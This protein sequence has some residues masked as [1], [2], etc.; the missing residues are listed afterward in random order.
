MLVYTIEGQQKQI[1][2]DKLIAAVSR[3]INPSGVAEVTVRRY[4]NEQ[5][6]VI[7]PEVEQRE[8]DQI[9]RII[10]TSGNLQF[11][12]LA[13]RHDHQRHHRAGRAI[14]LGR[15]LPG[16]QAEGPLDRDAAGRP[17]AWVRSSRK[18]DGVEQVLIM[19]D[20]YNVN[21]DYLTSASRE[22][23]QAT[24]GLC[25]A[26][27]FNSQGANQ[28]GHLTRRKLARPGHRL[29]AQLGHRA[30]QRLQSAANISSAISDRGQI[31]GS[32][33]RGLRQL[34]GR[35]AQRRQ[36]AGRAA[37]GADQR[38]E[39]QRPTGRRH[40]PQRLQRDDH[41]DDRR[42]GCSCSF[43]YRFAGIVAD[44][45]VLMNMVLATALMIM[46]KAAF[47]LP[48][49]A[50]FVLTVGMAVDANVLI[51]ERMREESS[52]GASLRMA[53]RNGF[54]RAMAT[55][56]DSHVTTVFT[57]VVLY[58][59]GTDQIKGFAV[60]LI[61]GLAVSLYTAVYVARVIFDIAERKRWIT[62]LQ[63][64]A[65][66]RRDAHRLRPLARAGHRRLADRD[67]DRHGGRLSA[68]RGFVRH[69]LHRR[70]VGAGLAQARPT[71]R[72]RRRAN[73]AFRFARR[74]GQRGR[75]RPEMKDREFKIDT[76]ERN[77]ALVQET[78]AREIRR[79]P[80][81]LTP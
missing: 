81:R 49:L 27:S 54:S 51:Y 1:D 63:H 58:T 35:R 24:G 23:R 66:R 38:A 52:R 34:R 78:A 79:R 28:F 71:P 18:H 69:R 53:I 57:A 20:D 77:M 46:I 65:D 17:S 67:R 10:S 25:I 12:I 13:N 75:Q 44:I 21:G 19:I 16:R 15:S 6:E 5:L 74:G 31:T 2:M 68:R 37:K 9:K 26:F 43:Y 61:L 4:G 32:F 59:I 29:R 40:D 11:R 7:V 33:D 45:A 3:R 42:R 72:H 70:R 62:R 36:P 41:L 80:W 8:V 73:L 48:G 39:D 30:G 76:S 56:I 14:P 47:T 50:G 22:P 60:S 55:I 64:D